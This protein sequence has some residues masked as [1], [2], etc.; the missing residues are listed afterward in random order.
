MEYFLLRA[1]VQT[2]RG[3]RCERSVSLSELCLFFQSPSAMSNGHEMLQLLFC[4]VWQGKMGAWSLLGSLSAFPLLP[5]HITLTKYA[6]SS[7]AWRSCLG[8][9]LH[10][11]HWTSC[12][13]FQSANLRAEMWFLPFSSSK[14]LSLQ[15]I[16][17]VAP[18]FWGNCAM[19]CVTRPWQELTVIT[20]MKR[21][22]NI[23]KSAFMVSSSWMWFSRS[24]LWN[25]HWLQWD[26]VYGG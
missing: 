22:N 11:F 12:L 8:P 2:A 14:G 23:W 13:Q 21:D 18:F 10:C 4:V 25:C 15:C 19:S 6:P 26:L 20:V 3:W 24:W 5:L 16:A 17:L 7:Q 1:C 9:V